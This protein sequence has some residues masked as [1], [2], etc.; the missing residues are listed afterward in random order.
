MSKNRKT[1]DANLNN[2]STKNQ[3]VVNHFAK[4]LNGKSVAIGVFVI[5][6]LSH[7]VFSFFSDGFYQH[8]EIGHLNSMRS[9]WYDPN[10]ILGNW[11]KTGYKLIYI[12]PSLLGNFAVVLLN[13]FFAALG[14]YL[15]YLL[16][17][18]LGSNIAIL[19]GVILAT[20]PFYFEIAFRNY[21]EIISSVILIGAILMHYKGR[22]NIATFLL[23]YL[24]TIR[25]EMFPLLAIYGLYL[26]YNK[27]WM[28]VLFGS[29]PV[30]ALNLWGGLVHKDP[31]YILSTILGTSKTYS[32]A[33]ARQGFWH[34]FSTAEVV[35]GVIVLLGLV[36]YFMTRLKN[37][38]IHW[39]LVIPT[40][41]FFTIQVLFNIISW[42]IGPATGGNLRYMVT[43]SPLVAVMS[44]L[45]FES[46]RNTKNVL[47]PRVGIGL[48]CLI[49][50]MYMT[51]DNNN[52]MLTEQRNWVPF[53]MSGLVA[54]VLFLPKSILKNTTYSIALALVSILNLSFAANTINMTPEEKTIGKAAKWYKQ[55]LN[56]NGQGKIIS[57]E[58]HIYFN[59]I[60]F[61]YF[62]EKTRFDFPGDGKTV[63]TEVLA[64]AP[65]GSIIFWDSHYS[66]RPK[67]R[68]N[69]IQES[70]YMERPNNFKKIKEWKSTDN[71]F[72]MIAF[73]KIKEENKMFTDATSLFNKKD[74]IG[75]VSVL[76]KLSNNTDPTLFHLRG[77]AEV[78][79][80]KYDKALV[81]FE[82]AILLDSSF[83]KSYIDRAALYMS[84]GKLD[85]A[86]V[87]IEKSLSLNAN[88]AEGNY[89]KALLQYS[90]KQYNDAKESFVKCAKLSPRNPGV[91]YYL[92]LTQIALNDK[93]SACGNFNNA[94]ILGH[95]DA[96]QKMAKYCK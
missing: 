33:Y 40:V 91:Y 17:K 27:R 36:T 54:L 37:K 42:D 3:V 67:L 94:K 57:K 15:A 26:M 39:F 90:T 8:D 55:E 80:K 58:D 72:K 63:T 78:K 16:A 9:F 88:D 95:P 75:A 44:V 30:L 85:L 25:Q 32:K 76:S 59:H 50:L 92:A 87:D 41:Y 31:L 21:S 19:A 52:I 83:T 84:I 64:D 46:L 61:T 38:N 96:I 43:I 11:P 70:Y 12:V 69:S 4:W 77:K 89:Y 45:G 20:Q 6:M 5:A 1:I 82:Q 86:K 56:S 2:P 34:Y 29:I 66:Y 53:V 62:T 71:Q 28:A 18:K 13:C 60:G 24:C 65:V 35:F 23:A 74:Y 22:W 93:K 73:K 68:S 14:G 81:S 48:M 49:V 7:I 10:V 79:L 51:Y 47:V